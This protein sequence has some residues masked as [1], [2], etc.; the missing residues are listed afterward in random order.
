MKTPDNEISQ[1]SS[2]CVEMIQNATSV[3]VIVS[4]LN[5]YT[6]YDVIQDLL[7]CITNSSASIELKSFR[8]AALFVLR[9]R[10]LHELDIKINQEGITEIIL[11]AFHDSKQMLVQDN[12]PATDLHTT[13]G[14]A[15]DGRQITSHGMLVMRFCTSGN[16]EYRASP[17]RLDVNGEQFNVIGVASQD[18]IVDKIRPLLAYQF[19][20]TYAQ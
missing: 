12:L 19:I 17:R 14:H 8:F 7:D 4:A 5:P 2:E 9:E 20:K 1:V 16:I 13:L 18:N 15:D 11:W 6:G 3:D 10:S